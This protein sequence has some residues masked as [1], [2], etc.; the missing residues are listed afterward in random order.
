[1]DRDPGQFPY[2]AFFWPAIAAASAFETASSMSAYFLGLNGGEEH[3]MQEPV[4]ATPS[5]I[6][7]QLPSVRLHDFTVVDNGIPTLLCTPLALHGAAIADLADGHSLVAALRLAGIERLFMTAWRS[8]SPKMRYLGIDDYLADLNILVD[9]MGGLVDLIGL[10]QGGW[11]SL[12][13]AGRFPE[14]VRKLVMAG[15]PVDIAARESK[16]SSIAAATPLSMF[17]SL[18][19]AGDGRVIGRNMARFWGNDTDPSRIRESLQAFQPVGSPEFAHLEAI[20]K[21]WNAWTI[22]VPG[23]Y[24]LEV[25]EKLYK[26]N[27]LATGSFVALGQT[28]DLTRVRLPTYL[29][30]GSADEVV[31]PEQVLAVARLTATPT[32]DLRHEVAPSNHLGLFMGRQ[33]LERYWPDIALWMREPLR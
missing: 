4:G 33:T 5:K 29:L 22:D 1:M 32:E 3:K 14:K 31:A 7:L 23:T 20:F 26:L 18:V 12:V 2:E 10:C 24:Y 19:D 15:S 30:A 13:Y 27:Q 8:A 9:Q 25:V 6:A 16:L 28:I 11:L 17:Q 21:A